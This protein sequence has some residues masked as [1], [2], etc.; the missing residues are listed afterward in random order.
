M[1]ESASGLISLWRI[2]GMICLWAAVA[3]L[4]QPASGQ[5]AAYYGQSRGGV[6]W[7]GTQQRSHPQPAGWTPP[8][9]SNSGLPHGNPDA[10]SPYGVPG[11]IQHPANS[12]PT[13]REMNYP[14]AGYAATNQWPSAATQ[15]YPGQQGQSQPGLFPAEPANAQ[16]NQQMQ[17]QP[18]QNQQAVQ[19]AAPQAR[20]PHDPMGVPV[21]SP[22][23]SRF[24]Q[25]LR[26]PNLSTWNQNR[27]HYSFVGQTRP[28]T[29]FHGM[30]WQSG[31]RFGQTYSNRSGHNQSTFNQNRF[32]YSLHN[33]TAPGQ[34]GYR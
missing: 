23:A 3:Q 6:L 4:P 33:I 13:R 24:F 21:L 26:G 18:A 32:N 1:K 25:N 10:V 2:V 34:S 29:Q 16:W 22:A 9:F 19:T 27:N 11:Y 7:R 28:D 17:S 8:A 14:G 20:P 12:Q 30:T 15:P 31:S 5:S